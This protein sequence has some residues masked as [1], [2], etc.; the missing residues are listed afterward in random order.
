MVGN[1]RRRHVTMSVPNDHA[2]RRGGIV[3]DAWS[4]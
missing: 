1:S 3:Q 2:S 4:R